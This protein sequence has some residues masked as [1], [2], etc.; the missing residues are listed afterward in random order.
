MLIYNKIK[1]NKTRSNFLKFGISVNLSNIIIEI[2]NIIFKQQLQPL[3]II[4]GLIDVMQKAK[5]IAKKK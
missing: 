1:K 4:I 5:I 2:R 3:L